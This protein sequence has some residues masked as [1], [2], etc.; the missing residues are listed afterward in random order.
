MDDNIK[1]ELCI[2]AFEGAC[3]TY[4]ARGMILHSDRGSQFTSTAFRNVLA[5]HD[6]IQRHERYGPLLW[7]RTDGEL[8]CHAEI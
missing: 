7:Q 3:Q 4:G 6:A 1:K 5:R 2:S 8:L